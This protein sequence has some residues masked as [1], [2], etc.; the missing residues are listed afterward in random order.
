MAATSVQEQTSV[1]SSLSSQ[2][3]AAL[4]ELAAVSA[5]SDDPEA[6]AYSC[7]MPENVAGYSCD[8]DPAGYGLLSSI[9]PFPG[10]QVNACLT[11]AYALAEEEALESTSIP[12]VPIVVNKNVESFV[13]YF[14]TR[15]RKYF[16]RW[17]DRSQNYMTMLR[18]IMRENGLPEDLSYI[19]FIESGINPTA[20]SRANAVGMWQ[21]IRGTALKYG[22]RVDWWID[23][24]M[25]P[26]KATYAAAKYFRNLYDQFGS[27][28]LAAAGYN[29]GEGKVMRAVKKHNSDDFWVLAN[30]KKPFRRETKDYV[31]KYLA[32]LTIAKDPTNYGFE[33]IEYADSLPY[34]KA[35]VPGATDLRV[36]AEAAGTTVDEIKRLNPELLRWF[37]P[38]NYPDYEIKIP[39]G[40][41][42]QFIENMS[43]IPPAKR[44]AFLQH[45]VR[46]GETVAKIAKRYGTTV[47]PIMYLNNL[48]SSKWV[49]PGTILMVPVRAD[50]V[51]GKKGGYIAEVH[52]HMELQS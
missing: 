22:L 46:K 41:S 32:A 11:G 25:D 21:F 7:S 26:E 17:R 33:K 19:A 15:G 47:S 29:A 13:R 8:D 28:Y 45:K 39:A 1:E 3:E 34:E 35:K 49:K 50:N 16:E 37:T 10:G 9:E 38:P 52:T 42:A 4:R 23:E 30:K 2:E 27:W 20:R 6:T 18:S 5:V 31:P 40:T 12:G 14:Q 24:R 51:V 44:I 36:I 43:K 48:K